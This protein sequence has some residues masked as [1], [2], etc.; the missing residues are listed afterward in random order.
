MAVSTPSK[1][2]N[3]VEAVRETLYEAMKN[4]DRTIILGEDV[5]NRGNVFLITKDFINEFGPER[6]IDTHISFDRVFQLLQHGIRHAIGKIVTWE[7]EH[8]YAIHRRASRSRYHICRSRTD[9]C[10]ARE[11]RQSVPMFCKC[12]RRMDH[13]LLVLRFVKPQSFSAAYFH[14]PLS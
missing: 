2:L 11:G 3:N 6:V 7:Q 14:D 5:G 9:R 10:R 4:D 12:R 8:R 13:C 1:V